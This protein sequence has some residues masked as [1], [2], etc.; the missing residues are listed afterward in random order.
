[1]ADTICPVSDNELVE[2]ME[3]E[4]R[5]EDCEPVNRRFKEKCERY[6]D[7]PPDEA[8]FVCEQKQCVSRREVRNCKRDG[9][10]IDLEH[11]YLCHNGLCQNV[12][13]VMEC[14]YTQTGD[15]FDC[16][17]KRNCITITGLFDCTAGV[18]TQV[19]WPWDCTRKC[20]ELE[21]SDSNVIIVSGD[22]TVTAYCDNAAIAGTGDRVWEGSKRHSSS[23]LVS[24]TD[25]ILQE[26]ET[27]FSGLDCVDGTLLPH[28]GQD[29]DWTSIRQ[30]FSLETNKTLGR[31]TEVQRIPHTSSLTIFDSAKVTTNPI[32][33]FVW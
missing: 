11:Q 31:R 19:L 24:C 22:R 4:N 25:V 27:S 12:S 7:C 30:A 21:V 32:K 16:T 20:P 5:D 26:N 8:P 23:L 15:K 17:D 29:W 1:M 3:C 33:K 2:D 18:C 6:R 28:Q 13:R 9:Q 10:C 14:H